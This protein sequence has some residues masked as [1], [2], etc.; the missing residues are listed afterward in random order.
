MT[1]GKNYLPNF[2]LP[3]GVTIEAHLH[4]G[5]SP[6]RK[7]EVLYPDATARCRASALCGALRVRD[8]RHHQD[9]LSGLLLIVAD[10]I[11]WAKTAACPSAPVAARAP[12]RWWRI[13]SALPIL[14]RSKYSLLFERFQTR[15]GVDA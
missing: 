2:P 7:A 11:G 5:C 6:A 4:N 9:G 1:L 14:T 3:P 10:F 12:A 8:R 15:N 13:R